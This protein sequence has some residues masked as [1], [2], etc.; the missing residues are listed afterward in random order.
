GAVER[1][2]LRKGMTIGRKVIPSSK[3]NGDG[4]LFHLA[5]PCHAGSIECDCPD[6]PAKL[7]AADAI[8]VGFQGRAFAKS[9]RAGAADREAIDNDHVVTAV[10]PFR[11]DRAC[12]PD[13]REGD[14]QHH[15]R[16]CHDDTPEFGLSN[17]RGVTV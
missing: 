15:Y 8:E 5:M 1:R 17:D 16:I 11:H 13:H 10:L 3:G 12:C 7:L 14:R 2:S 9:L 6:T 4:T